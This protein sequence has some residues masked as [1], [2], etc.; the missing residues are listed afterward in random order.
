MSSSNPVRRRLSPLRTYVVLVFTSSFLLSVIFTVNLI[1]HLNVV[2]LTPLQLVL[3]G[4][5]LETTVFL[6]EIPTGV[7]ADVKSRRL[8]IIIGYAVMGLGFLIEGSVPRFW[9]VALAQVVWGLGYTFTSGATEAWIVDEVGEE[10]AAGAFIGGAQAGQIGGLSAIP[11]S[12]LLGTVAVRLPIL[13]GGG[14]MVG[15][16]GFLALAMSE[17]GFT[18]TPAE[19]RTTVQMMLKTVRDARGLIRRQPVLLTILAIGLFFGLY[20]EGLDRLGTA[21]L[22][23]G[24]SVPWLNAVDPVIWVGVIS[25]CTG[26]LC[27]FA[28]ELIRKRVD[29]SRDSHLVYGLMANAGLIILALAG[30]ALTQNFWVAVGFYILVSVLRSVRDPLNSTWMNDRID[31]SQVRATMFSVTSQAD[32]IGQIAGGPA[33]GAIGNR[34]V[35]AALLVSAL[36]LT[37]SV[38]LHWVARQ[39]GREEP[40]SS[41]T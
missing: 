14:L 27:I 1:Y 35:R 25:G 2:G 10:Q 28:T 31:D 20:S 40:G 37:P 17:D 32:A 12:I 8:S 22:I 3:V 19:D 13:L 11:I 9:A 26:V 41:H 38:P 21:H 16:A 18:P 33:V 30:F 15:L 34:S 4:T 29:T 39:R 7:L 5:V 36:I 24:F 6:F 23:Q